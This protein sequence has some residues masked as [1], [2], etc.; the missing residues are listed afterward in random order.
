M[1]LVEP[2]GE[3]LGEDRLK[4]EAAQPPALPQGERE[5]DDPHERDQNPAVRDVRRDVRHIVQER[6]PLLFEPSG[7]PRVCVRDGLAREQ[8]LRDEEAESNHAGRKEDR[9]DVR[10]DPG[11][12]SAGIRCI[13]NARRSAK[14]P[15]PALIRREARESSGTPETLIGGVASV[16]TSPFSS[17]ISS[18]RPRRPPASRM[19]QRRGH[20][21]S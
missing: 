9:S 6:G 16:T 5:H 17:A 10:H 13:R 12:E 18:A 1:N 15:S 19:V 20:G 8:H 7:Q 2:V 14:P 4:V 21:D 3:Y 11:N